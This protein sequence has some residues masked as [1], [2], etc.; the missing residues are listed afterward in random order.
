MSLN[1]WTECNFSHKAQSGINWHTPAQF[2]QL[3]FGL[4]GPGVAPGWFGPVIN[5]FHTVHFGCCSCCC[6]RLS[7]RI[8]LWVGSSTPAS[9]RSS[10]V[11][12]LEQQCDTLET[13]LSLTFRPQQFWYS[14]PLDAESM[15]VCTWGTPG[16][17]SHCAEVPA[18][19]SPVPVSA[20]TPPLKTLQQTEMSCCCPK[21]PR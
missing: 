21:V 19:T 6:L 17:P 9:S 4:W 11:M 13:S 15:S 16:R 1:I 5:Q 10:S 14:S 3:R 8:L 7:S 18:H 12:S 20:A 2:S